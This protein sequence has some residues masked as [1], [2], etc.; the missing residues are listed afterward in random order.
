MK[1][2]E[3]KVGGGRG[4]VIA[5]ELVILMS[6]RFEPRRCWNCNHCERI[7]PHLSRAVYTKNTGRKRA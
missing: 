1:A 7:A 4:A 6:E 3:R 5:S 2:V